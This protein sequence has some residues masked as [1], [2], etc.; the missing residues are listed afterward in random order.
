MKKILTSNGKAL[1]DS[2]GKVLTF[3]S[4]VTITRDN[5]SIGLSGEYDGTPIEITEAGKIDIKALIDEKKIPLEVNVASKSTLKTLLDNT[6]SCYRLFYNYKKDN[7]SELLSYDDTENV[8]KFDNMFEGCQATVIPE[9]N[10]RNSISLFSTFYSCTA[11]KIY[12]SYFNVTNFNN[13]NIFAF[14]YSL[15]A[16]IIRSFGPNYWIDS[17]CFNYCNH[18]LGTNGDKDG[19]IYVPRDMIETLSNTTNWSEVAT[20]FRALEDYT[21]DGT[22]TGEFDDEK[23]GLV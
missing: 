17:K 4:N 15:K 10:M 21:K 3:E 2:T 5:E 16:I 7:I 8:E 22:T 9:I 19:Y 12:I 14:C 1:V 6:K 20:Q 13:N 18:I 11:K 23:A